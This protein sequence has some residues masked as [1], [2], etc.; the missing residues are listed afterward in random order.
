[1][2]DADKILEWQRTKDPA[3]FLD[4]L[5]KFNPMIHKT[6]NQYQTTGL[7]KPT[8]QTRA[9]AEFINAI[10]T[11]NPEYKTKPSTHIWN[12]LRKVQR[13]AS[14]SITSGRIPEHRNLKRQCISRVFSMSS[15]RAKHR[16]N[17]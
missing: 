7:A 6:V 8:L 10:S 5:K 17:L 15:L 12:N 1:M 2:T 4:I 11:Y 16:L 14:E 13:T 9:K 3:L